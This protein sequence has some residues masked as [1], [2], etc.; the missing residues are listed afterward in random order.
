MMRTINSNRQIRTPTTSQETEKTKKLGLISSNS[1]NKNMSSS[2]ASMTSSLKKVG[3]DKEI[4]SSKK[5]F[6]IPTSNSNKS[7]KGLREVTPNILN[8]KKPEIK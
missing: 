4:K 5:Q 3:F 8:M 6:C 2:V 1:K 7:L